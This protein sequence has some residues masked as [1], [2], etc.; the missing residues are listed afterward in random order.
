MTPAAN[1]AFKKHAA[2][3]VENCHSRMKTGSEQIARFPP[4]GEERG[5]QTQRPE[6][7]KTVPE[8]VPLGCR[9]SEVAGKRIRHGS[10]FA[11][12]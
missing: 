4:N 12:P 11:T 7:T 2:F 10:L 9:G 8:V 3:H 5:T 6:R 1:P